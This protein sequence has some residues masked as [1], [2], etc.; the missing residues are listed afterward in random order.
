M[1]A[2]EHKDGDWVVDTWLMSCRVLGR[3]VEQAMLDLLVQESEKK[4]VKRLVGQYFPTAKN[5][6]VKNHY[7][8]LGFKPLDS[9]SNGNTRWALKLESKKKFNYFIK[10]QKGN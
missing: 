5:S 2:L 1:I 7:A 10:S 4:G 8:D 3:G 6:L 9:D